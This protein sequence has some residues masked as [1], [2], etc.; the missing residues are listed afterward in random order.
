MLD[1]AALCLVAAAAFALLNARLA[2]LP[3]TLGVMAAAFALSVALIVLAHFGQAEAIHA[4]VNG[5]VRSIDFSTVLMQGMLAYL[6]FAGAMHVDLGRLRAYAWQVAGLSV[7][8]TIASTVLVGA[9]LQW[10]LP[11]AGVPLPPALCWL[12]GA[13]VSPTDPIAVMALLRR[14]GLPADLDL[15]ISGESLF[16]DGV[17]IVLFLVL[18]G[19]QSQPVPPTATDV[20]VLFLREA[21]GGLALGLVLGLA[22][23]RLL[24]P[25]ADRH[26]VAVLLTL[27]AVTGGYALADHLHVSGALAMVV[28]GLVVGNPGRAHAMTDATRHH[29]DVFWHLVDEV[30][31][32]VLFVLVG[33]EITVVRLD[34]P[35]VT[36]AGVALLVTLAARW[37]TAGLPVDLF[38][39]AF[40]LPRGAGTVLTWG[41]LRGGISIAMALSVPAGPGHGTVLA[42]T[43]AVVAF[44]ILVQGLTIGRVARRAL[45]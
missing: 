27:A 38:P 34:V 33:L 45:G 3:T 35:A 5:L 28:A 32:A 16:N 9:A 21:G 26:D 36:A 13:L 41:G 12:F 17:G 39:R 42:M 10:L 29:V 7:L 23:W 11:L 18:L 8:G 31:N 30:L 1:I 22:T 4:F 43:Y 20:A 40:R 6:L 19:V 25:V 37:L 15:V 2:A 44:S 24:R 14:A